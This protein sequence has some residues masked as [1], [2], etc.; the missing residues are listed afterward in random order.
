MGLKD[1][2][3][4]IIEENKD[5][6]IVAM[7]S[8]DELTDDYGYLLMEKLSVEVMD[9]YESPRGDFIYF[10]KDDVVDEL[11]DHLADEEEYMNL[12]DDEYD[13][14]CEENAKDY[15]YKR[16]IVIW[17]RNWGEINEYGIRCCNEY[18]H[19]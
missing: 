5:L 12:S 16:A 7:V 18:Y 17:A 13:K 9:I 19:Q 14:V 3:I 1:E 15:F 11:R 6:D 10:D 2:F 8:T 4:K